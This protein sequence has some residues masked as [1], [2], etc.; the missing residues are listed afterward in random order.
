MDELGLHYCFNFAER[1]YSISHV[2]ERML[3]RIVEEMVKRIAKET[4]MKLL[5]I[6]VR[7]FLGMS[8]STRARDA[9]TICLPPSI[10]DPTITN[11]LNDDRATLGLIIKSMVLLL[12]VLQQQLRVIVAGG[13]LKILKKYRRAP[14]SIQLQEVGAM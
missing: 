13:L 4:S 7:C 6:I 8:E 9:L 10:K 12:E 1:F 5:K 2:L 3:K 11:M 14:P